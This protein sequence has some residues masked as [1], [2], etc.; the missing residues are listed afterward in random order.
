[1]TIRNKERKWYGYW[2]SGKVSKGGRGVQ[3]EIRFVH[4]I[5]QIAS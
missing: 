2:N 4:C 5:F 1:M 3:N